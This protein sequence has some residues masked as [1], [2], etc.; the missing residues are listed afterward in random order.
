MVM[1]AHTNR[2]TVAMF[3]TVAALFFGAILFVV[4]S[5]GNLPIASAPANKKVLAKPQPLEGDQS[6][7][8]GSFEE[9]FPTS[10]GQEMRPRW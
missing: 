1:L 8:T 5:G 7:S 9:Q 4:F 10:G 6:G 3:A 2:L